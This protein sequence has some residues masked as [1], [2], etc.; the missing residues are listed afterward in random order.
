MVLWCVFCAFRLTQ[1]E[2]D[3]YKNYLESHMILQEIKEN[4]ST[5]CDFACSSYLFETIY[6]KIPEAPYCEHE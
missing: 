2:R 5:I 4:R 6:W 3:M 1:H